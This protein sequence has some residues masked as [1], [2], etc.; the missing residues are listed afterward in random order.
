MHITRELNFTNHPFLWMGLE[1]Q[2]CLRLPYD[3]NVTLG[4]EKWD[5]CIPIINMTS[6]HTT[7]TKTALPQTSQWHTQ[8]IK[9]IERVPKLNGLGIATLIDQ[10]IDRFISGSGATVSSLKMLMQ[11]NHVFRAVRP[12][13]FILFCSDVLFDL[14]PTHTTRT[15]HIFCKEKHLKL[16]KYSLYCHLLLPSRSLCSHFSSQP[17]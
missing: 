3:E 17:I 5:Q 12:Y 4:T 16:C 11:C 2:R 7:V 10:V 13:W 9:L 1:L 8:L 6:L 15:S 14:T